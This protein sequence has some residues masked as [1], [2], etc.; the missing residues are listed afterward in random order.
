MALT[1]GICA[2]VGKEYETQPSHRPGGADLQD[3]PSSGL[4]EGEVGRLLSEGASFCR[5]APVNLNTV[6]SK[7]LFLDRVT[8][9]TFLMRIPPSFQCAIWIPVHSHVELRS[10]QLKRPLDSSRTP[11]AS[12]PAT[13]IL[14]RVLAR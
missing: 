13:N 3:A 12:S 5:W 4:G 1:A 7:V 6:D 8:V 14:R 10:H 11:S 9:K 2:L